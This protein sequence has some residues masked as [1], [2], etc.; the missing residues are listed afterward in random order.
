MI[1]SLKTQ[2]GKTQNLNI[3]ILKQSEGI[4]TIALLAEYRLDDY[5]SVLITPS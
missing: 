3:G 1:K 2:W 4:M 5:I